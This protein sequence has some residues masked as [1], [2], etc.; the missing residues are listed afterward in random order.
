MWHDPKEPENEDGKRT[1]WYKYR[2][3]RV[4][5][6]WS[7]KV[8]RL[9]PKT[10]TVE[11]LGRVRWNVYACP[12][13]AIT[14]KYEMFCLWDIGVTYINPQPKVSLGQASAYLRLLAELEFNLNNEVRLDEITEEHSP[15]DS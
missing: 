3:G 11:E 5:E 9:T 8:E 2:P 12:Q 1:S 7:K 15:D 4:P 6:I 13:D 14:A 10:I